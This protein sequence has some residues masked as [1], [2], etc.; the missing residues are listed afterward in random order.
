[1]IYVHVPF[2]RSK[3]A[4]CDFYSLPR[5]ELAGQY[6]ETLLAEW[7]S[8]RH[9]T[10]GLPSP[11][12]LYIGGGTPSALPRPMLQSIID[13]LATPS[14]TEITI[15]VNPED[16]DSEFIRWITDTPVSR[17]SMGIQSLRDDEPRIVGRRHTAARRQRRPDLRAPRSDHG[18]IRPKS[19]RGTGQASG[20]PFMLSALIRAWNPPQHHALYGPRQG[21]DRYG[22]RRNVHTSVPN[23][24]RRR[25]QTL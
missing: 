8:R 16:V 13:A 5:L 21:S 4:Y 6:C 10:E 24:S 3:C 22:G 9:E 19:E 7:R 20:T 17:V 11:A 25:L 18:I 14:M 12:T 23:G 1:M 15:E 2:C